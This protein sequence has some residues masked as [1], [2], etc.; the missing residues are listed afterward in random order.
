MDNNFNLEI[1]LLPRL[2]K[3]QANDKPI[4]DVG[5]V[6]MM[7]SFSMFLVHLQCFQK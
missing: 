3:S 4:P 7:S 2:A 5:P 6:I 1:S